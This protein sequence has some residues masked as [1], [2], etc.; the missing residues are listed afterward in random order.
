MAGAEK[1]EDNLF[2]F[3]SRNLGKEQGG[4]F[5]KNFIHKI[6]IPDTT[7][8]PAQAPAPAAQA[9]APA[10]KK[11]SPD[12]LKLN[13][14]QE[15]QY[16]II[17]AHSQ[18][19]GSEILNLGIK[20]RNGELDASNQEKSSQTDIQELQIEQK[21][22]FSVLNN[23]SKYQQE[24]EKIKSE[25]VAE[26]LKIAKEDAKKKEVELRRAEE[27][28]KIQAELKG[29][30]D[31]KLNVQNA[32]SAL[33]ETIDS[34]LQRNIQL[35]EH[36]IKDQ[37]VKE[38]TKAKELLAKNNPTVGNAIQQE[39]TGVLPEVVNFLSNR[40]KENNKILRVLK[41]DKVDGPLIGDRFLNSLVVRGGFYITKCLALT[42]LTAAAIPLISVAPL[43]VIALNNEE[44]KSLGDGINYMIPRLKEP[45]QLESSI[46][47]VFE[48]A[49]EGSIL[50]VA[51]V[52]QFNILIS[53]S[54]EYTN[55]AIRGDESKIEDL[56]SDKSLAQNEKTH[57]IDVLKTTIELR[58]ELIKAE[59]NFNLV[60][61]AK[62][63]EME[64]IRKNGGE[65]YLPAEKDEDKDKG[66]L[67]KS[68]SFSTFS[69]IRRSLSGSSRSKSLDSGKGEKEKIIK[70][71]ITEINKEYDVMLEKLRNQR[72]EIEDHIKKLSEEKTGIISSTI[73]EKNIEILKELLDTKTTDSVDNQARKNLILKKFNEIVNGGIPTEGPGANSLQLVMGGRQYIATSQKMPSISPEA[74]RGSAQKRKEG[75]MEKLDESQKTQLNSIIPVVNKNG[76]SKLGTEATELS[77]LS[78][79]ASALN[80][81]ERTGGAGR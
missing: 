40:A 41:P 72:S 62:D 26:K 7:P 68:S 34:K 45:S 36:V 78:A 61:S 76:S 21:R 19:I 73:E 32:E 3:F 28:E 29:A 75:L 39:K 8:A 20:I 27:A 54:G 51:G 37:Q 12:Y 79:S 50:K 70:E 43:V 10:F 35:K 6:S 80:R 15:E 4:D 59:K 38:L 1:K 63:E 64:L 57:K 65:K 53:S 58:K 5:F 13:E 17:L 42:A 31:A 74:E 66:G 2:S 23:P 24:I 56:Q 25:E 44:T 49:K 47:Q 67:V 60:N 18:K 71:N 48:G 81:L 33:M 30:E 52:G 16:Q 55:E 46:T 9:P 77:P 22:L 14:S 69:S 11:V